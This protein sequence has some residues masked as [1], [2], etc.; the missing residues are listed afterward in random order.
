MKNL[1]LTII[2]FNLSIFA[3]YSTHKDSR[4][5]IDELVSKHGFEESYVV[6]VLK[7]AKKRKTALNSV[8]RPAEKTKTWDDY[9]AIFLKKKRI[10]DGKKFIKTNIEVLEK[11]EKEFGVTKGCLL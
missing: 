1:L 4:G 9:R 3:D 5:V 11:A 2:L 8:A 7:Q 6:D 10:A